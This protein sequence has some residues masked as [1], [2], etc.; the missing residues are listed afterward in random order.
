MKESAKTE[1]EMR[2]AKSLWPKTTGELI[3]YINSLTEREH[4]YGTS[5]FAMTL[6]AQA[7]FNYIGNALGT[8]GFQASC[9]DLEFLKRTRAIDGP[10]MILKGS[11][12]LY[13]QYDLAVKLHEAMNEWRPWAGEAARKLLKENRR[14][15]VH[16]DVWKHWEK[17][18]LAEAPHET[19]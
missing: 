5:A 16:P 6:A 12:M 14:D 11:D 2:E 17:L 7:A 15:Q 4:D 1:R 10:F 3:E 8:T 19:R 18:A 13:P 9:A